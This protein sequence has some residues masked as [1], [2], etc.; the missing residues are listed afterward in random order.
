MSRHLTPEILDQLAF[1]HPDAIRS[2]VDIQRINTL[3]GNHRWLEQELRN[4]EPGHVVELG[5]GCGSFA[6]RLARWPGLRYTAVDLIPRPTGFP[7]KFRWI[8]GDAVTDLPK[9]EGG[10]LIANLFLHHLRDEELVYLGS[11][12]AEGDY[13]RV[14]CCE[15]A[16]FKHSHA[17][18]YLTRLLGINYVTRFDLH[19]SIN[20][21][22]REKELPQTLGF[23]SSGWNVQTEQT[24]LGI[25]RM[26]ATR[27]SS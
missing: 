19:A 26:S 2:R 6:R 21:G 5:A 7:R 1:D 17:L 12:L 27:C 18:G 24:L 10:V 22:F 15:P 11:K 20:A 4:C 14:L 23:C 13:Q 3:A 9:G 8:Q 16:R 25:Y